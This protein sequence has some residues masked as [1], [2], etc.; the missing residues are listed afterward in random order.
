MVLKLDSD[1]GRFSLST[2][3][4][5]PSPGDMLHNPALVFEQA[6]QMAEKFHAKVTA[7][8]VCTESKGA[9]S[10]QVADAMSRS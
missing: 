7:A 6:E 9:G 4:L 3:V 2:K 5:E 8:Q 1:K 10:G